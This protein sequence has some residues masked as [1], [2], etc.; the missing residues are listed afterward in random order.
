MKTLLTCNLSDN[1]VLAG[2]DTWQ[3]PIMT[4]GETLTLAL[5]FARTLNGDTIEPDLNVT[6]LQASLGHIDARPLSGEWAL[7]IGPGA[8]TLANTTAALGY[9][10]SPKELENAINA[11]TAV[12][13]AY[14]TASV[15]FRDGS[16]Y[17]VFAE[18]TDS[19]PLQVRDNTLF[20]LSFGQCNAVEIDGVWHHEVRLIQLPVD[21]TSSAER[22]LPPPPTVTRVQQG[23]SSGEIEWNEIQ[24]LFVRPD[25]R[26]TYYLKK[27][28]A[29][30]AHLSRDDGP[31][32][33]VSAL[34]AVLGGNFA[35]TLAADFT[36]DI[37]FIGEFK[38]ESHDLLEVVAVEPPP[39][40]L[41]FSLPLNR[42]ALLS[43]LRNAPTVTLP[44]EVRLVATEDDATTTLVPVRTSV[45]IQRPVN[46][47]ELEENP[48][49]D[50]LRPP[51]PKDY[52]A[53]NP[54]TVITGQQFFPAVLGNGLLTEFNVAHGLDTDVVFVWV[55]E[56]ITAGRQLVQGT[57]FDVEITNENSVK[58]TALGGAPGTNGWLAV[59]VSA[60]TVAAFA[61][62]LTLDID[63][64]SGLGERLTAVEDRV[65][66]LETLLPSGTLVRPAVQAQ[67][68]E[69]E[70][71][72]STVIF[73]NAR[74]PADA[75][76]DGLAT[77]GAKERATFPSAG[78]RPPG[79]L[80]AIHIGATTPISE[81]PTDPVA[82]TVY[83]HGGSDPLLIPGGLGRRGS[84][85]KPGEF[86]AHD[87]RVWYHVTR[88]GVS[89]TSYFP[90]DFELELVPPIT[91]ESD[92]WRAGQ[93]FT[94][95]FDLAVAMI[96]ASTNAQWMLAIEHG[97]VPSDL[98]PTPTT[99][100][101]QNVVWNDTPLLAQRLVVSALA[102]KRHFGCR[103][104]RSNT[105]EITA[106]ILKQRAW[107]AAASVPATPQFA[108]RVRLIRFD[109]ENSI[110]GATGYAWAALTEGKA[111]IA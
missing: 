93:A 111:N 70:I 44:F 104:M 56:N 21:S 64:I 107:S 38:G 33:V 49:V 68:D 51:S 43:W 52:R 99:L 82:G 16:W 32:E 18:A 74:L 17:I 106:E 97:T 88:G 47:P 92:T 103:V 6:A 79:L 37:E 1:T 84:S 28:F 3:P 2:G 25:F 27:G 85:L 102:Q 22:I 110:T 67:P 96:R 75:K 30:T 108:L 34:A 39:G 86:A 50:W 55:R 100:N 71:P 9:A 57:D 13:T 31:E 91:F 69:I 4:F 42:A 77:A 14:G 26:A 20:P 41:T 109:T 11:K 89:S 66:D 58:I 76:V 23:G 46:W 73:P 29:R 105:N 24:R 48:N 53:F 78:V 90:S 54:E 65:E 62:G 83:L 7:Q 36:I 81:L 12:T 61:E 59:V 19:V 72:D 8:Q 95:E 35:T 60:Q 63:Q 10:A 40:D 98:S 101:L 5:R 94:L 45:T 87:G 80:P 15:R